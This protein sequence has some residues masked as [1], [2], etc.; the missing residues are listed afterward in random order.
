VLVNPLSRRMRL[1]RFTGINYMLSA[2]KR[3][4]HPTLHLV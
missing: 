1:S 3:A 2:V 4:D